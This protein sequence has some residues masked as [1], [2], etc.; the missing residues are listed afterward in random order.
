MNPEH[1]KIELQSPQDLTYLTTQ[2]R[3]AALQKLNLHLPPVTDS[4]EPDD[5][6]TQVEALVDAFV[7]H[8]LQGMR[9]NISINGI[10][11]VASAQAWSDS[12]ERMEGVISQQELEVEGVEFEAFDEKLRGRLGSA[13]LKRD[14]LVAKISQHRRAT[15]AVAARRFEEQWVSEM[16]GLEQGQV[17]GEEEALGDEAVMLAMQRQ[18]EV[19]KNWERAVEGLARLNKGLPE[20]RARLERCGDV[21]GYLGGGEKK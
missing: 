20:T 11:V 15:P 1:R 5:L 18:D 12:G 9:H 2:I 6:R 10:D 21:V 4:A 3:T 7:A 14:A 19:Q 8:V 17:G 16:Q 13:V